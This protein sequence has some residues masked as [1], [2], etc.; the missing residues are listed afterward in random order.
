MAKVKTIAEKFQKLDDIQHI[1]SRPGMYVGS[2]KPHISNKFI[3][4]DDGK[5][6]YREMSYNPALLKIVNEILMNSLDES[7]RQGTKLDTVWVSVDMAKGTISI[8]DNGGIPVMK[9]P[10][11]PD[12]WIPEMIFSTLKA[13]SNFDDTEERTGSG[14]N[15]VGSV[16]TNVFSK[17]FTVETC[18]GKKMFKQTFGNNMRERSEPSISNGKK[19]GTAISFLPDYE[20]FGLSELDEAHYKL[21]H[22]MTID[23][24]ACNPGL[25]VYWNNENVN[26]KNFSDYVSMY[27]S[28][29]WC[30]TDG[31]W[32]L[33]I[34]PSQDGFRQVSFVNSTETYDGGNH[35]DVIV[36]QIVSA[37]R[38]FFQKKHKIEIKPSEIKN[39]LSIYLDSVV[40]NPAFSSQTKEK[41][42]TEPKDFGHSYKL[43]EKSIKWLLKSEIVES[44]LDWVKQKK[45]AE[46]SKMARELNKAMSKLK[47]EK[48]IDANGKDR[49][50]CTLALFEGLSASASFR[51][52]RNPA[53]Q[54]AF[55]LK[56]KFVNASDMS[57]SKLAANDE[58]VNLMASMGLKIGQ[59]A[60][61]EKLRYGQVIIYTDADHDGASIAGLLLNF[62]YKYW[63]ELFEQGVIWKAMTP[64]V[65]A[66]NKKTKNKVCLYDENEY[67]TWLAK[68]SDKLKDWDIEYKKGLGSLTED[69]YKDIITCPKLFMFK[70]G[71]ICK[72]QLEVWFGKD[73][74]SRKDMVMAK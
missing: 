39:H 3:V 47:V 31:K 66:T 9:H 21:F 28:D 61:A 33:A 63:P 18:D 25:S 13:G 71:E 1:L 20:K 30:E 10:E 74:K 15:G 23:A 42:I 48:L 7:K 52:F 41:L 64:I 4:G 8:K 44:I 73:S 50:K 22:K 46:E 36:S 68:K 24:A 43:S 6:E 55:C 53:T 67:D 12:E 70:V 62:F 49:K 56:G 5:M 54:G 17:S 40:V 38:D 26:I 19:N 37:L 57:H 35:V 65:V 72:E 58:V 34:S 60:D 32:T 11:W 45:S 16:L 14:T 51:K 29:Y 69:E 2:I 27:A 59:R